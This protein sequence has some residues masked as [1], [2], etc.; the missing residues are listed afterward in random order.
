MLASVI[1]CLNSIP[2]FVEEAQMFKECFDADIPVANKPAF[3]I[4]KVVEG[5]VLA[6]DG[7]TVANVRSS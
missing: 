2:I 4:K 7:T 5:T 6:A 1:S 3:S